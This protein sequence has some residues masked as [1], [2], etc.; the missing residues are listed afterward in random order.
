MEL[1][2]LGPGTESIG[3]LRCVAG[4]GVGDESFGIIRGVVPAL[5]SFPFLVEPRP[6]VLRDLVLGVEALEK[7][8]ALRANYHAVGN[9]EG[10]VAEALKEHTNGGHR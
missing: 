6:E 4:T 9:D 3:A 1:L 7:V 8:V 2:E 5:R 10:T